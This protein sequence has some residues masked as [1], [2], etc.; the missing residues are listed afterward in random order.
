MK[1]VIAGADKEAIPYIEAVLNRSGDTLCGVITKLDP[2]EEVADILKKNNIPTFAN[3]KAYFE[4][5]TADLLIIA[6]PVGFR[7]DYAMPCFYHTNAFCAAPLMGE[8]V[9]AIDMKQ[10]AIR[11]K[12]K[13]GV[14]FGWNYTA[15]MRQLK[16]DIAAGKFGKVKAVKGMVAPVRTASYYADS[17][18]RGKMYDARARYLV[19]DGIVT[20]GGDDLLQNMME[21][22]RSYATADV[23]YLLGRAHEIETFDTCLL[24]GETETGCKIFY[25]ASS[26]SDAPTLPVFEY[27]FEKGTVYYNGN[28]ADVLKAVMADG[29]ETVYGAL[30]GDISIDAQID[31]TIAVLG[32]DEKP[33][34]DADDAFHQLLLSNLLFDNIDAVK[35]LE[36][37]KDGDSVTVAGL[38]AV[39]KT[40]YETETLPETL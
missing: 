31:A 35:Q 38:G 32:T 16:A 23:K 25:A 12:R 19:Y 36:A 10:E 24:K 33:V 9:Y 27:T 1:F 21:I 13:L 29:T 8:H 30:L 7:K 17:E 22:T 20:D 2:C 5:E 18:Y 3:A 6:S 26:V 4:G 14:G 15:A 34:C 11:W 28:E 37:Q 39:L 40:A